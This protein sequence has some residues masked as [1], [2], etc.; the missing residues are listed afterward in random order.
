MVPVQGTAQM[1]V[2]NQQ[3]TPYSFELKLLMIDL[4]LNHYIFGWFK[5]KSTS[6]TQFLKLFLLGPLGENQ[7]CLYRG[8]LG[9]LGLLLMDLQ[10]PPFQVTDLLRDHDAHRQACDRTQP[11][12]RDEVQDRG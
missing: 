1:T 6:P 10:P 3:Q 12:V 5:R 9:T 4:K 7:R 11:P 2:I 8:F